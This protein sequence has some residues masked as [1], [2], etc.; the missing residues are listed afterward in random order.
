MKILIRFL[1]L[2][3][4]A[5]GL[6]RGVGLWAEML[7]V[8]QAGQD[9]WVI[10]KVFNFKTNGYFVDIGAVDGYYINEHVYP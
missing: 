7:S 3:I 1:T 5:L 8:S 6:S 10:E 9:G 4:V 2:S